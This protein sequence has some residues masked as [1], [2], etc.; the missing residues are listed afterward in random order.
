VF[1]RCAARYDS[2]QAVVTYRSLILALCSVLALIAGCKAARSAI[3]DWAPVDAESGVSGHAQAGQPGT[4]G[5]GGFEAGMPTA[6]TGRAGTGMP[7]D[8]GAGG[9]IDQNVRF[10]WTQTLPPADRCAGAFFVGRFNCPIEN[11][12]IPSALDGTLWLDMVGP[13][14]MQ[15]LESKAG[16]LNVPLSMD[17]EVSITTGASG[18]AVCTSRAFRGDIPEMTLPP[19]QTGIFFSLIAGL[20]CSAGN[21]VKGTMV[22]TLA[23]DV[24]SGDIAMNIGSC[25]CRGKFEARAAQR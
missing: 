14:E 13:S 20:L 3:F 1:T 11:S 8:S 23:R 24:L 19:E 15:L 5:V 10:E 16:G 9:P 12:P 2:L 22:G 17:N 18:R 6:G 21:T 25:T 4:A 7:G